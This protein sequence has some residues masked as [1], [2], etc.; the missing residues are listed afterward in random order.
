MRIFLIE[1]DNRIIL[2]ERNSIQTIFI[3]NKFVE[4][5]KIQVIS[6]MFKGISK[7]FDNV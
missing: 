1:K 7:Y 4:T 3:Q 5:T 6:N 2:Y